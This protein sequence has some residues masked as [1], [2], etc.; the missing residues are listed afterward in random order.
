MSSLPGTS[1]IH[2]SSYDAH[3]FCFLCMEHLPTPPALIRTGEG[4]WE[5]TCLVCMKKQV[6]NV[7]RAVSSV[8]SKCTYKLG[9][10]MDGKAKC[11]MCLKDFCWMHVAL[12]EDI[13]LCKACEGVLFSKPKINNNYACAIGSCHT[14]R[15]ANN[16]CK[17]CE[18]HFC[19]VHMHQSDTGL[20]YNCC[21]S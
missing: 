19:Q 20:C 1:D 6:K 9:C 14:G 15:V 16:C 2:I 7:G 12:K 13:L 3:P 10:P 11:E 17:G 5:E 4:G 8:L 18:Q 21:S